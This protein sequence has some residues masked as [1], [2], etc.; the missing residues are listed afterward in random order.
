LEETE[1]ATEEKRI[2]YEREKGKV[3]VGWR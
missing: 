3:E 2:R 1:S